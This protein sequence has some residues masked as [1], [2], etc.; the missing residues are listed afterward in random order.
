[1]L[2]RI[3][4]ERSFL[5]SRYDRPFWV[6]N[7]AIVRRPIADDQTV[8]AEQETRRRLESIE[9]FIERFEPFRSKK[10]TVKEK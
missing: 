6:P 2:D 3:S 1:M 10:I 5:F 8:R 7:H 4:P 9:A